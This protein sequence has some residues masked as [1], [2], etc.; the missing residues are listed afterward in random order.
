MK[1]V[2]LIGL[3]VC[4]RTLQAQETLDSLV[5]HFESL[6]ANRPAEMIYLQTSKGI[7]ETGEDLWFKAYLLDAQTH[8][9][10][11]RSQTL[12]LQM[13]SESSGDAVW[14]EKYTIENGIADGHVYVHDTL[15]AG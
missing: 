1:F 3:A 15:S 10:S 11:L 9:L 12:Y 8:Y 14:Q 13:V 6:A 4:F 5:S 7:Y 2:W